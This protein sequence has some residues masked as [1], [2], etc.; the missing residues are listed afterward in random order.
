MVKVKCTNCG[1]IGYTAA[2]RAITCECGGSVEIISE[3]KEERVS[4]PDIPLQPSYLF[5]RLKYEKI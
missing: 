1:D 2:P 4:G 5:R 3:T